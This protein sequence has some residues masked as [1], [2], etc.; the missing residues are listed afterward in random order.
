MEILQ[1][2]DQNKMQIYGFLFEKYLRLCA[3]NIAFLQLVMM[4]WG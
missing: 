1:G 3:L 4:F 2:G